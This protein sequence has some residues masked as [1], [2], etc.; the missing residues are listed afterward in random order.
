MKVYQTLRRLNK[1]G[2]GNEKKLAG[3]CDMNLQ[4]HTCPPLDVASN[5]LSSPH[6]SAILRPSRSS[7]QVLDTAQGKAIYWNV[8]I[9]ATER[10]RDKNSTMVA[11]V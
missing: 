3:H 4:D 2:T 10:L 8:I 7:F 9:G 6:C 1:L 11:H 5:V